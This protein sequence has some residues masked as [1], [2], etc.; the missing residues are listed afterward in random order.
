LK[1]N[2]RVLFVIILSLLFAVPVLGQTYRASIRGTVYDP[3]RGAV[4]GATI[5]LR[6]LDTG[7]ARTTITADDG[8]YAIASI[9]PGEYTLHVERTNFK[10]SMQ[11]I[12]QLVN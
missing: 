11:S 9:P 7:E 3:N 5:T 8:S 6:N 2:R 10:T 12:N 4:A 1:S